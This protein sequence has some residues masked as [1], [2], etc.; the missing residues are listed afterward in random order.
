MIYGIG[1]DQ[2]DLNRA[3]VDNSYAVAELLDS[4]GITPLDLM[5]ECKIDDANLYTKLYNTRYSM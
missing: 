4:L 5:E 3:I 2:V 1:V